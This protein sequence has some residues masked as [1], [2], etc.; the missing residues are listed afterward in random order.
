MCRLPKSHLISWRSAS[1]FNHSEKEIIRLLYEKDSELRET[2]ILID[3]LE[4]LVRE[5]IEEVAERYECLFNQT[6]A[7]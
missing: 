1:N 3:W 7:W 5:Q 2:Q 6:T 4:L